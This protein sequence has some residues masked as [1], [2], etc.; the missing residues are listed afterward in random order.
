MYY[1]KRGSVW[2]SF[3][4]AGTGGPYCLALDADQNVYVS[5]GDYN[6]VEVFSAAPN[7]ALIRTIKTG[8]N[9]P[10]SLAFDAQDNLWVANEEGNDVVKYLPGS[11]TIDA[12]I[13]NGI[14]T[15]IEIVIK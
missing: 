9:A 2:K 13:S 4:A 5:T 1:L 10:G 6:S 7:F 12:T 15:P 3:A 14:K 11:T 8:L